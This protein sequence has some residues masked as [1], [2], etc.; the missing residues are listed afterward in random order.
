MKAKLTIL[1]VLLFYE[2]S[3]AQTTL[4][5]ENMGSP[6]GITTIAANTFSNTGSLTYSNGTQTNSADVRSTS[7]SSSYTGASGGGN[8]YFTS[9]SGTYGFSIES[10]NASNYSSLTLQYGYKKESASAQATFSV[11]YWNGTAWSSLANSSSTLFNEASNGSAVWYLAKILSLPA[12]AQINDLKI[13]FVKTGT[14]SIRIDDVKL[15][16][17]LQVAPT[18]VNSTGTDVANNSVTFAGNVTATGG[19]AIASTGTVYAVTSINS[20][21]I[22]GGTGVLTVNTPSPN[23]GTGTFSNASGAVL[24]PNIQYSY[25]AYA[26]KSDGATGYGTVATFIRLPVFLQLQLLLMLHQIL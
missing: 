8:V 7:A 13:R 23:S 26:T 25:N 24:S 9:T 3:L 10:I 2:C 4:F 19:S 20:N 17:T 12:D 11:D 1:L 21:P 5:T 16:G 6:S 22:L 15:T 14:T 18:V